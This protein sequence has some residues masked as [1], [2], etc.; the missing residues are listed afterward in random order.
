MH[1][2]FLRSRIFAYFLYVK[3]NLRSY[4]CMYNAIDVYFAS[5]RKQLLLPWQNKNCYIWTITTVC[6]KPPIF[7]N[8]LRTP[9]RQCKIFIPQRLLLV[10]KAE[11][12]ASFSLST[13]CWILIGPF[14]EPYGFFCINFSTSFSIWVHCARRTITHLDI[15]G[16]ALASDIS[17]AYRYRLLFPLS[18]L[19]ALLSFSI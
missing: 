15:A 8:S 3:L 12:L 17:C 1:C 14:V 6:W 19:P 4:T 13:W 5:K 10:L 7:S 2:K 11:T 18:P 16:L 9:C